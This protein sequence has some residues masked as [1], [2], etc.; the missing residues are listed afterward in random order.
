MVFSAR[1]KVIFVHGCYWHR[2]RGAP[3]RILA[4]VKCRILEQKIRFERGER[5]ADGNRAEAIGLGGPD[6]MGL[7]SIRHRTTSEEACGIS[8]RC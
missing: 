6:H 8:E 5:Q 7:R 1:R 3:I 2:H 4:Q